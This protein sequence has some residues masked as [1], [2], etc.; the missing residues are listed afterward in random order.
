MDILLQS[1][2]FFLSLYK[3][4]RINI[5]KAHVNSKTSI[6]IK[7]QNINFELIVISKTKTI[8]LL[9]FFYYNPGNDNDVLGSLVKHTVIFLRSWLSNCIL[10][11][12][13]YCVSHSPQ[14]VLWRNINFLSTFYYWTTMR[15]LRR[16]SRMVSQTP[17]KALMNFSRQI[18]LNLYL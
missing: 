14:K 15:R 5:K 2:Y 17:R 16:K 6:N 4:H 18:H 13:K 10:Q 7:V 9:K 3:S 1:Y 11:L 12:E 8:L